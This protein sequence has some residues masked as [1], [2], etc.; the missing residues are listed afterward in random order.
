[1]EWIS[2]TGEEKKG[3]YGTQREARRPEEKRTDSPMK[4]NGGQGTS[5]KVGGRELCF[6]EP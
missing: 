3:E 6:L 1:M 5:V 4:S 2:Q